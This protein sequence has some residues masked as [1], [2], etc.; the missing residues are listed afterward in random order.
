MVEL[1]VEAGDTVKKGQVLLRIEAKDMAERETQARAALES[2]RADL[3]KTRNDFERFKTLFEK[4][5]V[6]KKDYDDAVARYEMAQA[7]EK[8]AAAALEESKTQLSY[9]VVTAPFD[10]I[11]AAREVNLGDLATPG[12]GLLDISH[13]GHSSSWWPRSAS[14]TLP[15]CAQEPLSID[16]FL[17]QSSSRLPPYEK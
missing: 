14:S 6:A 5:S 8:R 2:A 13:A 11:V 16:L 1:N 15:I 10:G 12:K 7:A 3:A 17:R 4:E 9:A